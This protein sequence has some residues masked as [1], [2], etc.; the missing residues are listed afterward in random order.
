MLQNKTSLQDSKNLLAYSAGVDSTA[1]LFLLLEN[2]IKFDIAIV[3]YGLRLQAKEEVAYA[4]SLAAKHNF[5]CF[6]FEAPVISSNFEANARTIRYDFFESLIKEHS[7]T[8]LLTAHHLGDRLEW[9]LMQFCRGAGCVELSGMHATEKREHYTLIRP[10]LQLDK[11]E[12]LE[13]LDANSIKYFL[14]A[15]NADSKYS[16]N[17]F[18]HNYANPLL[19]QY[20]KGIQKSF[21]YLDEDVATLIQEADTK[22]INSLF[23]F[24]STTSKRSDIL[25]IDKHL[26][27]LGYLISASEKKLLKIDITVVVSRKYVINQE[28]GFVFIVPFVQGVSLEKQFK[29]KMRLLKIEPKLRAYLSTDTESCETLSLLL[30]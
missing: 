23:Y 26:K 8:T 30:Q 18:R 24:K 9:M 3:N 7:Y 1:L 29:E 16:R 15:T 12:L 10:L 5:E 14:D 4:Q 11:A 21:E 19:K 22:S 13:Y 27:S 2:N 20:K 6:V 25:A 17:E 28:H